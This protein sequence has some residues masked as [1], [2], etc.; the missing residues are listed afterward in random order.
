MYKLNLI[1]KLIQG[2]AM[3]SAEAD[4]L[5]MQTLELTSTTQKALEDEQEELLKQLAEI[6]LETKEF[7][8][9]WYVKQIILTNRKEIIR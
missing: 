7:L 8:D 6:K 1:I 5:R 4:A 2:F 9:I 3:M